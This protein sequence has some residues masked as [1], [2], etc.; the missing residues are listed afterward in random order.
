MMRP[1]LVFSLFALVLSLASL[2]V[3]TLQTEGEA[4]DPA[5]CTLPMPSI[6]DIERLLS[7]S[8]DREP[9]TPTSVPDPFEMPRGF[10]LLDED[11][12]E[13]EKD[14]TRAVACF[15]TGNPLAVFSTYTDR[16]VAQLV[17]EL[18]GLEPEV[19]AGLLATRPLE[20]EDYIRLISIEDAVLLGDGRAAVLVLGE[21]PTDDR[22]PG[23]RLFYLEEVL[24]G[25]WL[26]DDVAEIDED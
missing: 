21:N 19:I 2:D 3:A 7:E 17:M 4:P 13:V 24:P 10:I 14:L 6:G 12:A 15:N 8:T 26:I 18:G 16:Y 5:L 11:R 1:I 20:P 25:R 9:I 22:P 23:L